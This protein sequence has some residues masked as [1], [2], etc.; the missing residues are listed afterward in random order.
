MSEFLSLF[1]FLLVKILVKACLYLK[2]KKKLTEHLLRILWYLSI[3]ISTRS[4]PPICERLFLSICLDFLFH[5]ISALWLPAQITVNKY[6]HLSISLFLSCY[7]WCWIFNFGGHFVIARI[8]TYNLLFYF[9]CLFAISWA[10]PA[11]YGGSQARGRI[12]TITTVPRREL[13]KIDF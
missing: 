4:S 8:W 9:F 6:L 11:A 2:K 3:I 7:K 5:F 13:P 10:S 1:I 12:G